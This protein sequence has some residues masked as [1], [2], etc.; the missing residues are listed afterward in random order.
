MP[1]CHSFN[2]SACKDNNIFSN[3]ILMSKKNNKLNQKEWIAHCWSVE[4]TQ[5]CHN[6][7]NQSNNA[8]NG[9]Y[10]GTI[11]QGTLSAVLANKT[12]LIYNRLTFI[13]YLITIFT[14]FKAAFCHKKRKGCIKFV[15]CVIEEVNLSDAPTLHF[16]KHIQN[17]V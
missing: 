5:Q 1:E 2:A 15:G 6:R 14:L 16:G 17:K 3:N 8:N 9:P 11:K 7:D 13:G 4:L 12:A 10:D